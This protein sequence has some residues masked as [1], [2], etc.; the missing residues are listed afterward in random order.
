[1]ITI[2][3]KFKNFL[4]EFL[5]NAFLYS[6]KFAWLWAIRHQNL[7]HSQ[8]KYLISVLFKINTGYEPNFENPKSFNEKIHWLNLN[9]RNPLITQCADKVKVRDYIRDTI[10]E[11]YLIPHLGIYDNPKDIDFDALPDQFVIKTNWGSGQN[12]I[13]EK[14]SELDIPKTIKQLQ[15]WLRPKSNHYYNSFEWCYKNISPK[16]IIETYIKDSDDLPDYKFFCCNGEPKFMFIAQD[17]SKGHDQLKFTFFDIAF[18]RLP[19]SQHYPT[20]PNPIK[21]PELWNEMLQLSRTLSAPFPL[22]R[23]D[24]YIT[25]GALKVGELTFCHFAGMTPF[26]PC[27]WDYKLGDFLTLEKSLKN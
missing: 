22:V 20:N 15:K 18:N 19:F 25:N 11:K 6:P 5:S 21:K 2:Y 4:Y 24:F 17:R 12:I 7:S 1:M 14:K 10:G 9:Y 8:I 23:V 26:E 13:C 27:E 16:I 3:T